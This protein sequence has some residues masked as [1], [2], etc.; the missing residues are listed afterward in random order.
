MIY[1]HPPHAFEITPQKGV[2]QNTLLT[3]VVSTTR[4]RSEEG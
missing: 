3:R 1:N 2:F 4:R